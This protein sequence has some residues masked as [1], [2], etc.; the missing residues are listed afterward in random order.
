MTTL[1]LNDKLLSV[2]CAV[3][4]KQNLAV[5][6]VS[7]DCFTNDWAKSLRDY[8]Y[9]TLPDELIDEVGL[10]KNEFCIRAIERLEIPDAWM[11]TEISELG[12]F[13]FSY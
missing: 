13:T 1:Q 6:E 5:N 11:A 2:L 7:L 10:K 9:K 12:Q 8:F 3:K 4:A